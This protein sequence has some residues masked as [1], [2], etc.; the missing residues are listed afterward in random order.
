M[1]AEVGMMEAEVGIMEAE[2][3]FMEAEFG[4]MEAEV[5]MKEAEVG[6]MEAEV[7]MME[8]EGMKLRRNLLRI[9]RRGGWEVKL[10]NRLALEIRGQPSGLGRY[11]LALMDIEWTDVD[12]ALLLSQGHKWLLLP[13]IVATSCS[14]PTVIMPKWGNN[15]STCPSAPSK[16]LHS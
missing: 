6:M 11:V 14:A 1:E 12:A 16:A 7:G 5:G 2:V 13:R 4:M 3:G 10:Q 15:P 8:A 9:G